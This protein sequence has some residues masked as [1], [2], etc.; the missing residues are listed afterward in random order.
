M[1]PRLLVMG[2]NHGDTE[3][4]RAVLDDVSDASIDYVVHVGDFTNAWRTARQTDDVARGKE[5]GVEQ[6][7]GVEPVLAEFD[8]LA[9]H[10]LVWV[11]GNQDYYGE[12][13]YDLSVG[14]EVPDDGVVS[15]G[16]LQFTNSLE[17]VAPNVVLVTHE[18]YWRLADEFDGLA[19]FCGNSH[20]G[21]LKDRRLNSSFL[22]AREPETSRK[23]F[24]GYFL[25]ELG[26]SG[27]TVEMQSLG[28]LTRIECD[29]HAE[30]GVQFQPESRGCMFCNEDGTLFREMCAS[31]FYGLTYDVD[32]DTVTDEELVDYAEALWDQPPDE[33]REEFQSYLTELDDDRYAPLTRTEDGAIRLA[34]RPYSY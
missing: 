1:T 9:K 12:L 20:R 30:R 2:D 27:L 19:H 29:R 24:G 5:R 32:R 11:Y 23:Q 16:D 3:S 28:G 31:G 34:E 4:I 7:R 18:E 10:G 6:L 26:E 15:V 17:R 21:R 25:V 13:D 33:F 22:Q 8:A 14:T